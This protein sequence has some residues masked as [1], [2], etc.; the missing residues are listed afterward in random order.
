[1]LPPPTNPLPNTFLG[2]G[3]LRPSLNFFFYHF[4]CI[5][6]YS[7]VLKML[8]KGGMEPPNAMSLSCENTSLLD[9]LGRLSLRRAVRASTIQ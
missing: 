7:R 5:I 3:P 4:L 8:V 1:M 2:P 9:F 6:F